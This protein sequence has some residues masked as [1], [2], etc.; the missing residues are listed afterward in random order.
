LTIWFDLYPDLSFNLLSIANEFV[1]FVY[2]LSCK[3]CFVFFLFFFFF[4]FFL[5]FRLYLFSGSVLLEKE[6]EKKRAV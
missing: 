2:L 6:E 4:F 5:F 1:V 3:F